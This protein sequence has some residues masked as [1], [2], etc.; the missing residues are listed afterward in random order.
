MKTNLICAALG[1]MM[2]LV[3]CRKDAPLIPVISDDS[4]SSPV[5][6]RCGCLPP[7]M[8][9]V[10]G[11]TGTSA[12]VFW[13]AMPETTAYQIEVILEDFQS[14][15]VVSDGNI[16]VAITNNTNISLSGLTPNSNYKYRVTT[17]CRSVI[18]SPSEWMQFDTKNPVIRKLRLPEHESINL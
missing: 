15:D 12:E 2:L 6:E 9:E 5:G 11:V 1:A 4:L 13:N 18:S 14:P 3:A 10:Q 8:F 7:V 16:F 17:I